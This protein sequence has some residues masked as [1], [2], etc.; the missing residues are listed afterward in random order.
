MLHIYRQ[1]NHKVNK[2][3]LAGGYVDLPQCLLN[4]KRDSASITYSNHMYQTALIHTASTT[5][6]HSHSPP[7]V[8]KSLTF[9]PKHA[10][11]SILVISTGKAF[12]RRKALTSNDLLKTGDP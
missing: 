10:R 12:R 11:P 6:R 4:D 3:F 1:N 8:I 7:P 2:V 5:P 9:A